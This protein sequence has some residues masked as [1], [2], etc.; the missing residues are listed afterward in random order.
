MLPLH[1][2]SRCY[3]GRCCQSLLPA[4]QVSLVRVFCPVPPM[5]A[6]R[7]EQ[8]RQQLERATEQVHTFAEATQVTGRLVDR[9]ELVGEDFGRVRDRQHYLL[10]V[11][12]RPDLA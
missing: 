4:A 3:P 9:V 8:A 12:W 11:P 10:L 6:A 2:W 7:L 5:L 1:W